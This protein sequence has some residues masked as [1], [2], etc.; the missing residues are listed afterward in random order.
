M[1]TSCWTKPNKT[2]PKPTTQE[3]DTN[4]LYMIPFFLEL[5]KQNTGICL[6]YPPFWDRSL[7]SSNAAPKGGPER[8]MLWPILGPGSVFVLTFTTCVQICNLSLYASRDTTLSRQENLLRSICNRQVN[9]SI[10]KHPST[11]SSSSSLGIIR[12]SSHTPIFVNCRITII[13][14][15]P[16]FAC[17]T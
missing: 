10:R 7:V 11:N 3:L 1:M 17:H 14:V 5:Y 12:D 13:D 4:I 15:R 16:S 9:Y 6:W 2:K 8:R